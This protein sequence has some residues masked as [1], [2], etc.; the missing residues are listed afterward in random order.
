MLSHG[1]TTFVGWY[2]SYGRTGPCRQG[3]RCGDQS[4]AKAPI[5]A[6]KRRVV[7]DRAEEKSGVA[8]LDGVGLAGGFSQCCQANQAS[9]LSAVEMGD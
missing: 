3:R 6:L 2:G 4:G 7:D 9:S 8:V 5:S 1:G